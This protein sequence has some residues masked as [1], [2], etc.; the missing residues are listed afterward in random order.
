MQEDNWSTRLGDLLRKKQEEVPIRYDPGAWEAFEER[1]NQKR[2]SPLLWWWAG[3]IAASFA[4]ILVV[5]LQWSQENEKQLVAVATP[6]IQEVAPS[7][8]E[9][10]QVDPESM[11]SDQA[12][13]QTLPER[14]I[15]KNMGSI[16]NSSSSKPRKSP[17][18]HTSEDLNRLALATES[19]KET[20]P[21]TSLEQTLATSS[22]LVLSSPSS[23]EVKSSV[24]A[25]AASTPSY[26]DIVPAEAAALLAGQKKSFAFAIGL[27]PG[28]GNS[29]ASNQVTSGSRIGLAVQADK[30]LVGD[31]RLGSGL[32]VNYQNQSTEGPA[33]MK[34]VGVNSLIEQTTQVQQ[35]QVDLPL[36][37]S[38]S[39]TSSKSISVQ[40]GFSNL[41]TINQAAQQELSYTRQLAAPA[42]GTANSIDILKSAQ[43]IETTPLAGPSARFFPFALANLGVNVRVYETKKS[44]YLLMPFYSYP[45]QDISGT[46]QNPAVLGAAFKITFST[47]K[48]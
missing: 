35:V 44:T 20:S 32:G 21:V 22:Q 13:S 1:R 11:A 46:G 26:T 10:I 17:Y 2:S 19:S 18:L 23:E 33:A 41:L 42:D 31:L 4:L 15:K 47:L 39:L 40:A 3:G 36:Y 25:P 48:K 34:M 8:S 24:S 30:A 16:L 43:V 6:S 14:A 38:Y 37:L 9:S 29:T 45:I 7:P 28:F 12:N 5:G 27:G